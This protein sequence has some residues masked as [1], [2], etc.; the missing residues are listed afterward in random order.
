MMVGVVQ[1][2]EVHIPASGSDKKI[3]IGRDQSKDKYLNN[4]DEE[5]NTLR[6][7]K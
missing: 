4:D 1:K 2:E 5:E 7:M 6:I 3:D